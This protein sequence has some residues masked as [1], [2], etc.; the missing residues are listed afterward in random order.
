MYQEIRDNS[1]SFNEKNDC[2]VV[3]VAAATGVR[4]SVAHQEMSNA[5]RKRHKGAKPDL[6]LKALKELGFKTKKVTI[7]QIQKS[8][9]PKYR[10]NTLTPSQVRMLQ[11]VWKNGKTYVCFTSSHALTVVD[12]EVADWSDGRC[13]RITSLY[14][15]IGERVKPY[16]PQLD[17][18]PVL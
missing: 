14:E 4:Y 5:G 10:P 8:Y 3:A 18:F 6:V 16:T 12:G 17:L 1:K 15:V 13:H 2:T 7:K 11:D 9:P